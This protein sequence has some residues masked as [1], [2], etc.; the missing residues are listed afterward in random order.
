MASQWL[1][2]KH[3]TFLQQYLDMLLSDDTDYNVLLSQNE[4]NQKL[5]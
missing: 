4:Q 1:Q 3:L 5:K 2:F